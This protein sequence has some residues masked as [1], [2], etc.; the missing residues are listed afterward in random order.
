MTDVFADAQPL[1]PEVILIR[2]TSQPRARPAASARNLF[3]VHVGPGQVPG[4]DPWSCP[5][6]A[7]RV[8]LRSSI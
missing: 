7:V 5:A 6:K 8:N 4:S 3:T 2:R 1:S